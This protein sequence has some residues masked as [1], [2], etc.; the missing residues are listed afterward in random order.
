MPGAINALSAQLIESMGFEALYLSGAVLANSVGGMPDTGMMTLSES[1]AHSAAIARTTTIPILADADT[2]YG[3]ADN[4]ARTVQV[5]EQAGVSAIHLEDQV[6]P[7]RC[8]HLEGK[9]L[10]SAEDFCEK[11]EAAVNAKTSEDFIVMARCDARGVVDLDETI[12]RSQMYIEAGADAIFPEGLRSIEE[13][14]QVGKVLD[15]Y[16]LANMTEFGT[17]PYLSVEEFGKLGYNMV[18]FPVTLQRTAMKAM[19]IVLQNIKDTGSNESSLE[20]MQ[21]RQELYDL[22][23]YGGKVDKPV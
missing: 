23:G 3:E 14:E 11:I 18:I 1:E 7:K 13:F 10:V 16:L 5:L 2:G 17:T 15:T 4:T 19:E 9:E 12:R 8:G 22:L 6:F 20:N 21:T